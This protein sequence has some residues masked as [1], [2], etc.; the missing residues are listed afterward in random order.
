MSITA[1]LSA[2]IVGTILILYLLDRYAQD[3]ED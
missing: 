1:Y 3:D 2:F